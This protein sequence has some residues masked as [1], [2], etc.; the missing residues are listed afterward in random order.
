M[1]LNFFG[2]GSV[3]STNTFQIGFPQSAVPVGGKLKFDSHAR[4]GIRGTFYSRGHWGEEVFYSFE[5]NTVHINRG[6]SN[7]DL[8]LQLHNYGANALY[9]LVE[10]ESHTL[11][12]F[13]S[14]GVG[15]TFYRFTPQSFLYAKNPAGANLPD[16]DNSNELAFNYGFG[17]K[18][19]STGPIGVRI[20]L[21]DFMGRSPS[22]GLARHSDDPTATVL[23][24][25]GVL[26][27][28]E[29]SVGLVFYFGKR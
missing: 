16:L 15:G 19:R 28:G 17:F 3:Y 27:N 11:L 5:P 25:S 6:L 23:P 18:T 26:H 24:A 8:K 1:E 4:L 14:A 13:L 12:P 29:F 10:T 22:F 21:R 9:Y 20:D 2:A 7:V